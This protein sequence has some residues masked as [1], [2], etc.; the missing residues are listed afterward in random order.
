MSK[1]PKLLLAESKALPNR[2]DI[3]L[4]EGLSVGKLG[5]VEGMIVPDPEFGKLVGSDV[6][7]PCVCG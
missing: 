2:R 1:L 6:G 5:A 3:P 7:A 4:S